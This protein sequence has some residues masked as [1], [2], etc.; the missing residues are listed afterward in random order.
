MTF[1]FCIETKVI[2]VV[3]ANC[4]LDLDYNEM[5][6]VPNNCKEAKVMRKVI[7]TVN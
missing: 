7:I 4:S 6:K 1:S 3:V 2:F 5:L